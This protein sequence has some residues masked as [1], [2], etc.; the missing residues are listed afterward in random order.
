VAGVTALDLE[1]GSDHGVCP[2]CG[3]HFPMSA[4]ERIDSLADPD[5]FEEESADLRSADP[6]EF[7]D[8]RPYRERLAEGAA[9]GFKLDA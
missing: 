9:L 6:L 1:T 4:R 7:F 3:H 5:T 8:L 2:H